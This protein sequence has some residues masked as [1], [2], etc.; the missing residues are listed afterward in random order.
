M[1][2]KNN[3]TYR[4]IC[5]ADKNRSLNVYGDSGSVPSAQTNVC[6]YTSGANNT[7]QQ[8]IYKE[9]GGN[10]Y[11][12]C[13]KN[14]NLALDMYTGSTSGQTNV[15]AHVYAPSNTSYLAF[16]DTDSGYIKIRLSKYSNKYL[17]ANQGDNGS[18]TGRTTH[19]KG[20]VYWYA[21]GLTDHSQE[22]KPVL[23][24]GGGSSGGEHSEQNLAVPINH[25]KI[26]CGYHNPHKT[27]ASKWQQC[28]LYSTLG[29]FAKA[30]HFG[31]DFTGS[32]TPFYASGN[33]IV[34]GLSKNANNVIGKWL[35]IKYYNV[36]GY[37]D[38]VA[39]YFHLNDISVSV[40]QKVNL[41]TLVATYGATGNYVTGAH[42]HVE[43]DTDTKAWNYT[44]TLSADNGGLC[45]GVRG[46]QDTTLN[47]AYVFKLK[48]SAPENQTMSYPES[49]WYTGS[50]FDTF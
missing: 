21:G 10:K 37:G 4:F 24:D 50:H 23:V 46:S 33:G 48:T 29:S 28:P 11:F 3:A 39:R 47:P 20:N 40:G 31:M 18:N 2:F 49:G 15:N 36:K 38:I 9:S 44:P 34:L 32:E 17:T 13:K 43:L 42:L 35:A 6:L 27:P 12:V 25:A 19:D 16:E 5:R 30:G 1:N 14:P 7:C 26:Q 22:W 41:S 45:A 8:W